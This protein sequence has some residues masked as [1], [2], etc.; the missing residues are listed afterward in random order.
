MRIEFSI[1]D[2]RTLI[3]IAE[4]ALV[5]AKIISKKD[6]ERILDEDNETNFNKLDKA[7]KCISKRLVKAFGNLSPSDVDLGDAIT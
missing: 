4:L 3:W 1:E 6:C 5:D 2:C 7:D